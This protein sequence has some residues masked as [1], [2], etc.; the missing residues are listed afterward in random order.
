MNN[1]LA[2]CTKIGKSLRKVESH[3]GKQKAVNKSWKAV[4]QNWILSK[5]NWILG[6]GN[7]NIS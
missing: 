4:E 2:G 3:C 5:E 6:K 1:L 7:L